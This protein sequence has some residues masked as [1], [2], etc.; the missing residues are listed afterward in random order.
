MNKNVLLLHIL[1]IALV[2]KIAFELFY[3]IQ[4][5]KSGFQI[6]DFILVASWFQSN[7][8]F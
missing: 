7:F 4:P 8:Y 3:N 6:F 2:L 1:T 5:L